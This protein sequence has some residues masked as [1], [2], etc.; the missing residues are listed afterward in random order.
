MMKIIIL[1]NL[2]PFF[3]YK[4]KSNSQ[5]QP[6]K[7]HADEIEFE[8]FDQYLNSEFMVCQDG[9]TAVAKVVKR[10]RDNNG[11]PIGRRHADPLLDTREYKCELEDGSLMRYHA[12]ETAENTFAWCDDEGRQHAALAE[13]VE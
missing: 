9:K 4:M 11:S 12:N 8:T 13:I 7:Q 5:I 10:A 2:S 1:T 3:T 6:A